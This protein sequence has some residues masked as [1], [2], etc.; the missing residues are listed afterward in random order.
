VAVYL[1]LTLPLYLRPGLRRG[2]LI[3]VHMAGLLLLG[4]G[5]WLSERGS[6]RRVGEWAEASADRLIV[7]LVLAT[8]LVFGWLNVSKYEHLG[9]VGK[10]VTLIAQP[11]VS[12]IRGQGLFSMSGRP[13]QLGLHWSPY[14]FAILPLFAVS[15][16]AVTL[17]LV[18]C[19]VLAL[20]IV[21]FYL[22]ARDALGRRVAPLLAGAYVLNITLFPQ[23]LNEYYEI[24]FAPLFTLWAL[25]ALSR[26]KYFQFVLAL[27]ALLSLREEMGALVAGIAACAWFQGKSPRWWLLPSVA[28]VTYAILAYVAFIP[29]FSPTGLYRVHYV[30]GAHRGVSPRELVENVANVASVRYLYRLGA[31]FLFV[32]PFLAPAGVVASPFVAAILASGRPENKDILYHYSTFIGP[33]LFVGLVQVASRG[34]RSGWL[35]RRVLGPCALL[36]LVLNGAM[37]FEACGNVMP[38][39]VTSPFELKPGVELGPY[40]D[41]VDRT[42]ALV[43]P[44]ASVV[45]PRYMSPR[46]VG[47]AGVEFYWTQEED[48]YEAP[49]FEAYPTDVIVD[50]N[51]ADPTTR[52]RFYALFEADPRRSEYAKISEIDGISLFRLSAAKVGAAP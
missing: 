11:L 2:G 41:A 31:P 34:L 23:F 45:L 9:F 8:F 14:L 10:D 1:L 40:Y 48:P 43:P 37:T 12:T 33:L 44:T 49:R 47:R 17:L 16:H 24:Q 50:E 35:P 46:A 5:S 38:A 51:T 15:P 7:G 4:A 26:G 29:H 19:G 36:V 3:V 20:S 6:L 18:R 22:I 28:G 27:A 25:L 30:T 39:Q 52:A 42:L 21:P 13:S 32:P